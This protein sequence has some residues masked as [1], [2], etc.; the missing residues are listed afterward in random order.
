MASAISFGDDGVGKAA[1]RALIG[2]GRVGVAI[3]EDDV[4]RL[5]RGADERAYVLRAVGGVEEKFGERVYL[6]L[7]VEHELADARAERRAA[8]LARRDDLAAAQAQLAGEHA[9]LCG[10]AAPVDAL[11]G[12]ESWGQD[13]LVSPFRLAPV[14]SERSA[15]RAARRLASRVGGV[16]GLVRGAVLAGRAARVLYGR[17]GVLEDELLL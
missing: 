11:E 16:V 1:A 3:R 4:A 14:R 12:D 17:D 5:E 13:F 10:L 6:L 9:Q 7:C 2:D 15:F 8:G